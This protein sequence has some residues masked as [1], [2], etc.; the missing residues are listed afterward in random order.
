[1]CGSGIRIDMYRTLPA[2]AGA[3]PGRN[4]AQLGI[5]GVESTIGVFANT[6]GH[7]CPNAIASSTGTMRYLGFVQ[8]SAKP[9]RNS[10]DTTAA[11]PGFS[12]RSFMQPGKKPVSH[13][14]GY[15]ALRH[16]L[17]KSLKHGYRAVRL[18]QQNDKVE[19]HK[20]LCLQ[21]SQ[22]VVSIVCS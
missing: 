10:T 14:A 13:V 2:T 8:S 16:P 7:L 9:A 19:P 5:W 20:R 22:S 12:L 15:P 4:C 21:P 18:T 6:A 11:S 17:P 3:V 1:M